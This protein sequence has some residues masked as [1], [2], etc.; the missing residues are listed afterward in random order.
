MMARDGVDYMIVD[1]RDYGADAIKRADY[2]MW[3]S[4]A[5]SLIFAGPT[6]QL[7]FAHPPPAAVVARFGPV[8]VIDLHKL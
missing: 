1:A 2:L 6:A 3:S 8:E 5:R 7:Y 4:L